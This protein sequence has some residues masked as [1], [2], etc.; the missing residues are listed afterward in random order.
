M[1]KENL[2]KPCFFVDPYKKIM[3]F[4][5]DFIR[6]ATTDFASDDSK[7]Y[8]TLTFL[9]THLEDLWIRLSYLY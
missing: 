2:P 1:R 4:T 8:F 7:W 6:K 5:K 3:Y 9:R